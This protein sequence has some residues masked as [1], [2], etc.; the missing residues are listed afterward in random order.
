MCY[1]LCCIMVFGFKGEIPFRFVI[2]LI[3][4]SLTL[5]NHFVIAEYFQIHNVRLPE[6][7][8]CP[9]KYMK[10]AR[11]VFGCDLIYL[12]LRQAIKLKWYIRKIEDK[13]SVYMLIVRVITTLFN[14]YYLFNTKGVLDVVIASLF[15]YVYFIVSFIKVFKCLKPILG[16]SWTVLLLPVT[17][18]FILICGS[19]LKCTERN[20]DENQPQGSDLHLRESNDSIDQGNF[21]EE[22][23]EN[24]YIAQLRRSLNLVPPERALSVIDEEEDFKNVFNED[25]I[26]RPP[27]NE[28]EQDRLRRVLE[29]PVP[30]PQGILPPI[31]LRVLRNNPFPVQADPPDDPRGFQLSLRNL[32]F[33]FMDA[34]N[35][36]KR[37][38]RLGTMLSVEM[39]MKNWRRPYVQEDRLTSP[40][41]CVCL[42]EFQTRE[43][44]MELHCTPGRHGH[45][46]HLECIENWS[47]KE[48]TCP[49]C[50]KNF[51]D[52]VRQEY[53]DG[54]LLRKSEEFKK[55]EKLQD[56]LNISEHTIEEEIFPRQGLLPLDFDEFS[57]DSGQTSIV[58]S[59]ENSIFRP[60]RENI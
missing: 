58:R 23:K 16:I 44:I 54:K 4:S 48:K 3:Y 5:Y 26:P 14:F 41:C 45:I 46:F 35:E 34:A 19:L 22:M 43:L 8:D 24:D 50:R 33:A 32:A 20:D 28:S 57:S 51:I 36:Q 38:L 25:P 47:K 31:D 60:A 49:L 2:F 17:L 42:E 18:P 56:S 39:M 12:N 1:L 53:R 7:L 11:I 30:R 21:A 37:F 59:R 6:L 55:V 29:A 10:V 15:I 27:V 40:N 13:I 9:Q 52:I